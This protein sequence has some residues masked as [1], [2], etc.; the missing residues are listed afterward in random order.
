MTA[1]NSDQGFDCLAFKDKVQSE[2]YEETKAMSRDQKMAYFR[3]HAENGPFA[4]VW[5]NVL[6]RRSKARPAK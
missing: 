1:P 3:G 4:K 5:K 6:L 2:I